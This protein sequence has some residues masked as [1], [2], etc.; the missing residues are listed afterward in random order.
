VNDW[1]GYVADPLSYERGGYE[2]CFSFYGV[3]MASWLTQQS[4]ESVE[5]LDAREAESEAGR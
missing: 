3:G 5:L 2:A 4:S 1:V